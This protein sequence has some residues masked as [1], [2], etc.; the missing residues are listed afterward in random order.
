[1][2]LPK[3]AVARIQ[4]SVAGEHRV[5]QGLPSASPCGTSSTSSA[6]GPKEPHPAD[7]RAGEGPSPPGRFHFDK[8][9]ALQPDGKT[10]VSLARATGRKKS[11][12]SD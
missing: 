8:D 5:T 7:D 3:S 12:M 9:T 10:R 1:M 2:L 4:V 11:P 6:Q